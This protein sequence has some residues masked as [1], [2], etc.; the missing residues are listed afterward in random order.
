[1]WTLLLNG[2][3][4]DLLSSWQPSFSR[5]NNAFAFG[6]LELSRTLSFTI[7]STP[8]NDAA[9][10]NAN[11][12]H[13]NGQRVRVYHDAMLF[14]DSVAFSGT[15]YVDNADRTGYKCVFVFGDLEALKTLSEVKKLDFESVG[16][17]AQLR[18][19]S[20]GKSRPLS[21][22][23]S[24]QSSNSLNNTFVNRLY[25]NNTSGTTYTMPSVRVA[26]LFANLQQNYGLTV[27]MPAEC[28][29]LAIVLDKLNGQ[30]DRAVTIAKSGINAASVTANEII[31]VSTTFTFISYMFNN[32]TTNYN[33][34]WF[35]MLEDGDVTFPADFPDD[36]FLCDGA[37]VPTFYGGY[38]FDTSVNASVRNNY[39]RPLAGRKVKLT[40]EDEDGNVIKY[41]FFKK[42]DYQNTQTG[43]GST[44]RRTQG[45]VNGR[46]ASVFSY[47]IVVTSAAKMDA[48]ASHN[49]W[50]RDNY[51][52]VGFMDLLKTIAMICG[53]YITVEADT[54]RFVS[55]NADSWSMQRIDKVMSIGSIERRFSNFEQSGEVVFDNAEGVQEPRLAS[56]A[57]DNETLKESTTIYKV[58]FSGG[59]GTSANAD[60]LFIGDFYTEVDGTETKVVLDSKKQTVA[61]IGGDTHLTRADLPTI[62]AIQSLCDT[63]TAIEASVSMSAFEFYSIKENQLLYLDGTLWVWLSATWS[64]NVAKF[65][66]QK[67]V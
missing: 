40:R 51:P 65:C 18:P 14:G 42:T 43:S 35:E 61:H 64:K 66:L 16:V 49:Y 50:L 2:Q 27:E 13:S 29:D 17:D 44:L 57:V 21:Y 56:Y 12:A 20:G 58:P 31:G 39:G 25:H 55:L 7:P 54:I 34:K 59:D 28:A 36:V 63:S 30:T 47:N 9:F 6:N 38:S 37:F 1:M 15:L 60:S 24:C 45:F 26:D 8:T 22:G 11:D 32:N 52:A 46:D 10:L 33:F 62:A 67:W 5:K 3:R 41:G 4:L 48:K 19:I 23:V 53:K